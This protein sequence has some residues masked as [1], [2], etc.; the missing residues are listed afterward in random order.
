[1]KHMRQAAKKDA[2]EASVVK[3][4]RRAGAW[5]MCVGQPYDLLVY[6]RGRWHIMEVKDGSKP[7]SAQLLS[8]QQLG[9][10]AALQLCGVVLARNEQEALAAIGAGEWPGGG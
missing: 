6:Y 10:L 9:T 1:M 2:N 3:A 8:P 7:P 5:V 4:L